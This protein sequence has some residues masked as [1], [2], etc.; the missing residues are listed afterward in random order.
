MPSMFCSHQKPSL[1]LVITLRNAKCVIKKKNKSSNVRVNVTSRRVHETTCAWISKKYCIIWVRVCSLS[2]SA[3]KAPAPCY[4]VT[5]SLPYFSTLSHKQ[6]D[7]RK[8]KN[9][10]ECSICV[11]IFSI[12]AV[13]NISHSKKNSAW[14]YHT[15]PQVFMQ[16]THSSCQISMKPFR[17]IFEGHSNIQFY[18]NP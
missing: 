15:C 11:W 2:Y 12:T 3:S 16:S 14:H 4:I 7:F 1:R 17:H 10:F 6:H 13:W 5:C 9:V 8:K 18:E